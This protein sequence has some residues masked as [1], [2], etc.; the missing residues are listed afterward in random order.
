MAG[1]W[2]RSRCPKRARTATVNNPHPCPGRQL[3]LVSLIGDKGFREPPNL[4]SRMAW[5]GTRAS[6]EDTDYFHSNHS[7]GPFC[8][9][10]LANFLFI[11]FIYFVFIYYLCDE[12]SFSPLSVFNYLFIYSE[13]LCVMIGDHVCIGWDGLLN[14]LCF[15]FFFFKSCCHGCSWRGQRHLGL[16]HECSKP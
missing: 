2:H 8:L 11:R 1:A 14:Y 7:R 13:E 4:L 3:L 15:F 16:F 5:E 12:L 10:L 9:G 6:L